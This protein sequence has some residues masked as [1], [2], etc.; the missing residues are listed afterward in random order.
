MGKG[1]LFGQSR[2][3]EKVLEVTFSATGKKGRT[4][5]QRLFPKNNPRPGMGR[6]RRQAMTRG[7]VSTG[8]QN[9][10]LVSGHLVS[11][12]CIVRGLHRGAALGTW[13]GASAP[14]E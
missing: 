5:G 9:A 1:A 6:N 11:P 13:D 3:G 12:R 4:E 2:G 10:A 7:S 8:L 14:W